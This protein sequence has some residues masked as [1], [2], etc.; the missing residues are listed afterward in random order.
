[1]KKVGFV[2]VGVMGHGMVRNLMAH[3][4]EVT[5]YTRTKEKAADLL[6]EGVRW[7]D[8]PAACAGASEAVITM[9]GYTEMV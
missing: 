6:G 9:V 8:S 7:A 3:G 1:M 2:G 4:F 5:I